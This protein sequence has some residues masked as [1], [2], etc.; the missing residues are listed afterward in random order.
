[1]LTMLLGGL[2]HGASWN[3]VLWGFIHGLILV[4]HRLYLDFR[5]RNPDFRPRSD[6]ASELLSTCA[7]QF[8]VLLA[9]IPFRVSDLEALK[10]SLHRF[11]FFDF[12]LQLANIGL[13]GT[14]LFSTVILILA[15]AALHYVS[16][17]VGHLD[18]FLGSLSMGWA[19]AISAIIGFVACLL[20]P[21]TDVPFIYFQF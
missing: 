13:G 3:F 20:W 19:Y 7:M 12:D 10:I 9:W 16:R 14:M 21:M 11:L 2:W 18:R 15:F 1:M 17:R 5:R 6:R 4:V 8:F